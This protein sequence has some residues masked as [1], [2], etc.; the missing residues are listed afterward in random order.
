[1]HADTVQISRAREA[2]RE[3]EEIFQREMQQNDA[4][5]TAGMNLSRGKDGNPKTF[6]AAQ[7]AR[8]VRHRIQWRCG[9]KISIDIVECVK[10][11]HQMRE[12]DKEARDHVR[13]DEQV[14]GIFHPD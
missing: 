5:W 7:N 3:L 12:A 6:I 1:M 11:G 8:P 13:K 4:S 9:A 10:C 14:I 2:R